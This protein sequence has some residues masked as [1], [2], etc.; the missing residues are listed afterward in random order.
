MRAWQPPSSPGSLPLLTSE[1]SATC[2]A[3][4]QGRGPVL[5]YWD[6]SPPSLQMFL[7]TWKLES[8]L[9]Y[10]FLKFSPKWKPGSGLKA[11]LLV[12]YH[13]ANS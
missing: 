5:Q 7:P 4:G 13:L 8:L 12:S 9:D 2:R 11:S 10:S 1:P 6:A 3:P